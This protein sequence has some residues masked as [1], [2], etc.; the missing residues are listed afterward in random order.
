MKRLLVLASGSPRRKKILKDAGFKFRS[1][2]PNSSERFDKNLTLSRAL[3]K[4]SE[5]KAAFCCAA[6]SA[7]MHEPLLIL[8]ADTV[9]VCG[10]KAL[11]KPKSRQHALKM[12][13]MLSGRIHQVKTSFTLL[14]CD[15]DDRPRGGYRITKRVSRVVTTSVQLREVAEKELVS[16]VNSGEPFDKAGS[17]AIQGRAKKFVKRIRGDLL[18][19]VGLPLKEVE[20]EIRKQRWNVGSRRSQRSPRKNSRR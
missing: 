3:K 15:L 8:S 11:G 16:Y 17:Y 20:E 19:V 1:F 4:I 13:K 5:K 12:L 10:G 14:A 2:I 9:V 18:N 6:L 7:R